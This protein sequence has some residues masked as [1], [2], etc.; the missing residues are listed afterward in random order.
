M[1]R[2]AVTGAA[3][4]AVPMRP[5]AVRRYFG[6]FGTYLAPQWPRALLLGVLVLGGVG[7]Q[8]VGPQLV[9]GLIDAARAGREPW[10]LTETALLFLAAA[11]AQQVIAVGTGYVGADVGWTATKRLRT[12]LLAHCLSLDL[13]FHSARTP[14]EMIERVDTDVATLANFFSQLG[15]RLLSSVLLLGGVLVLLYRE[16]WRLGLG[17]TTFAA[18]AL[19]AL[20]RVPAAAASRWRQVRQLGA[21]LFGSVGEYLSGIEDL[22][23]CGAVGYA[24]RRFF[25]LSRTLMRTDR[26]ANMAG[27]LLWIAPIGVFAAGHALALALGGY[28]LGAGAITLGTV[29]LVFSYAELL[30][31]PIDQINA[32][33]QDLQRAAASIVR[34]DEL[35]HTTS[36]IQDGAG[37]LLPPGPLSVEL[38]R[39]TFSYP[40]A[41]RGKPVLRDVS[42]R[43]EPGQVLGLLGRTGSGKT[44]IGRLLFRFYDA[45][46]GSVRVGG[47]DVRDVRVVDLRTRIGLVTQEVQLFHASVRDNL[48][49]FD[50]GIPDGLIEGALRA[51]GLEEWL[52][53]LPHGL[54]TVLPPGGGG[55]SAGQA[56]LLAFARVFLQDP[57]LI[58]LD[59]ASSR[60]DPATERRLDEAIERLLAGRT[61]IVIAHRLATIERADQILVLEDGRVAAA[62]TLEE[63]LP[64]CQELRALMNFDDQRMTAHTAG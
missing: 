42:F 30:R 38:D 29:F 62:G 1:G 7:L 44:T 40:G 16:D 26:A 55:L 23:R 14:G 53:A 8:L 28:L 64:D 13:V 33:L 24:L 19:A 6:L 27:S 25:E 46:L 22:R 41:D 5:M 32:Q 54:D 9:R 57:D 31:R 36:A 51:L 37:R 12:D 35:L 48:T 60:L 61:A 59:E 10:V 34:V 4:L 21:E 47:V 2:R 17:F 15:I 63:L 43:L 20:R 50:C 39:V 56:Q 49:F 11:V 45:A 18:V 52:R 58:I 3:A